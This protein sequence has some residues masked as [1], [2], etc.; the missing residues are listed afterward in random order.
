MTSSHDVI[1]DGSTFTVYCFS[2][3]DAKETLE[4]LLKRVILK[5]AE[6]ELKKRSVIINQEK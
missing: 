4:Q 2:R 5:N 3:D 6:K 1:I